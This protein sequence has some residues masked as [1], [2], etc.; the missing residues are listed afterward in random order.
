MAPRFSILFSD[1]DGTCVHYADHDSFNISLIQEGENG[2]LW[3]ATFQDGRRAPVLRLPQSSSGSQGIISIASLEEYAKL[4]ECGIK[5]VLISG[6]RSSTLFERLPYLPKADVY[7]C[8]SGGRIFYPSSR[9]PT[10]LDLQE[11]LEW[12]QR[13]E[14]AGEIGQEELPPLQRQGIL[15]DQFK[16]LAG[17]GL[18]LDARN[19]T[20]AF[21][22]KLKHPKDLTE[23]GLDSLLPGLSAAVNLGAVDI[24]GSTS[25]KKNA[26]LYIMKQF[27]A[28][29]DG[30]NSVFMCGKLKDII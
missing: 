6:C 9:C 27:G 15:W 30:S 22:V 8:E 19:Y 23:A 25:G 4:R 3:A 17:L 5:L 7:V 2:G 28:N 20:T 1:L 14:A 18:Q 12:R 16:I 26:G 21:R 29:Q 24:Y 13:H 10:S 11:D